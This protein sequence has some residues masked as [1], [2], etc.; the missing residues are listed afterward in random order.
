MMPIM[1]LST[2]LTLRSIYGIFSLLVVFFYVFS[3]IGYA[4]TDDVSI[5]SVS[6]AQDN[7]THKQ[8]E[9]DCILEKDQHPHE[10]KRIEI[11]TAISNFVQ[12]RNYTETG[13]T[14]K[15]VATEIGITRYA[16][17]NWLQTTEFKQFNNWLMSLRIDEAKRLMLEHPDWSNETVSKACGFSNRTYFQS[18]FNDRVGMTPCQWV[19]ENIH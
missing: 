5:S 10:K 13:I 7:K 11:E 12:S 18:Q 16:L 15:D 6:I 2:N 4:L 1:I 3:F 19:K 17:N 8:K 9:K 14:L